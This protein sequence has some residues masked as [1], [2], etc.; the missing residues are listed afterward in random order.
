MSRVVLLAPQRFV[1]TIGRRLRESGIEGPV[2]T[3]TAGW[4]E[5]ELELVEL[6][7]Y[8][9][10]PA[11]NLR[12]FD[13][14]EGLMRR[15]PELLTGLHERHDRLRTLQSLY[16]VR[17]AHAL[18]A[19]REL[20]A[21][22]DPD[23]VVEPERE[24]AIDAVRE[25]D[26]RHLERKRESQVAFDAE[27][28]LAERPGVGEERREIAEVLSGISALVITGGHVGVLRN[29]LW[30]FD[31]FRSLGDKPIFAWSAG[32]M[33][34]ADRIVLFHDSPP[35]GPGNAEIHAYGFGICPG[36]VPL[37]HARRRL[38]LEDRTRVALFARRFA[39]AASVT[40]EE[41]GWIE[42]DGE[43]WSSTP[44]NRR[45]TH[46]GTLEPMTDGLASASMAPALVP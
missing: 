39:P 7:H 17:L 40:L 15:D 23:D 18:D 24:A 2:A 25:L 38:K 21:R 22:E 36:V 6:D 45:L 11:V 32:A 9:G 20:L 34:V 29:R 35:Q 28:R 37:P 8:I 16:R 1:Q 41:G 3:V 12:L 5:R 46:A 44:D 31:V 30:L 27:W 10:V 13:R 42:W 33:A 43:S 4:Q 26:A 19:A 14:A